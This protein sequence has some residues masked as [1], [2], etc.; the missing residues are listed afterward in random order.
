MKTYNLSLKAQGQITQIPDSQKIFGALMFFLSETCDSKATTKYVQEVRDDPNLV[1]I[2]N[3]LPLGYF[4]APKALLINKIKETDK[5]TYSLIKNMDYIAKEKVIE[6]CSKTE[7]SADDT[8]IDYINIKTFQ[9]V[10]VGI[11][12]SYKAS[13]GLPSNPFSVPTI[14]VCKNNGEEVTAYTVYIRAK[15]DSLLGKYILSLKYKLFVLGKR[16]SQGFNL[17]KVTNVKNVETKNHTDKQ[18]GEFINLG[19]LLPGENVDLANSKSLELFTSER[20]PYEMGTHWNKDEITRNY[21]SFLAPG[22]V[23]KLTSGIVGGVCIDSP[24]PS[25]KGRNI[26]FGNAFLYPLEVV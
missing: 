7:L 1:Q 9:H 2:S 15:G 22:S 21:L 12:A 3:A 4:P 18:A 23:V 5:N 11:D 14:R 20:R 24:F 17:F 8:D 16:S 25:G 6:L 10:R 13:P 26:V 19:M